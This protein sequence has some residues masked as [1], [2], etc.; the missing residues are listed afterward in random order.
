MPRKSKL[1]DVEEF[2]ARY[3]YDPETGLLTNKHTGNIIKGKAGANSRYIG[4]LWKGKLWQAHRVAWAIHHG[5]DP[6]ELC[7]DHIDGDGHNNRI[8]NLRA[9]THQQNICNRK[10]TK[11][12][13][14]RYGKYEAQIKHNGK[15]IYIG[16]YKTEAEARRA[17][18]EKAKEL[19]GEFAIA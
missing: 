8:N 2:S 13:T 16:M 9:C 5:E 10:P 19:F 11:G 14:K 7:I 18:L 15:T 12:Y 4:F 3:S 17:Y 1:I 6:G